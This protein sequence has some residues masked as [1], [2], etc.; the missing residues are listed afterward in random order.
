[1]VWS[2]LYQ[3]HAFNDKDGDYPNLIRDDHHM[4]FAYPIHFERIKPL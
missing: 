1:M 3:L 4:D 2:P